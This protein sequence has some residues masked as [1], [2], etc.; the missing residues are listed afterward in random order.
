MVLI[1]TWSIALFCANLRAL[2]SVD[3]DFERLSEP[4]QRKYFNEVSN[5]HWV[6]TIVVSIKLIKY[7]G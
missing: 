2:Q 4:A 6:V 7:S 1:M 3:Y 5:T